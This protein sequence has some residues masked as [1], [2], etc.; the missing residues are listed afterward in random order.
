MHQ[1]FGLSKFVAG[2]SCWALFAGL[3]VVFLSEANI[4]ELWYGLAILLWFTGGVM[5]IWAFLN[6]H[7]PRRFHWLFAGKCCYCGYDLRG[8]PG[9]CPECGHERG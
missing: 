6:S 8:S 5:L 4:N 3:V 1:P 9:A 7:G 2:L